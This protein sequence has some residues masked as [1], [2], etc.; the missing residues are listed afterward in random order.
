MKEITT[1]EELDATIDKLSGSS[2][3]IES[4]IKRLKPKLLV[5]HTD[6]AGPW[7]WAASYRGYW[8][9]TRKNLPELEEWLRCW[10]FSYTVKKEV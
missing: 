8:M 6:E 5:Y 2:R 7:C 10:G 9:N 4:A 3:I 1:I